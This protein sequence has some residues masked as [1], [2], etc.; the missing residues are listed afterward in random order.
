[1]IL[2]LLNVCLLVILLLKR[3]IGVGVLLSIASLLVWM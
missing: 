1:L 2:M 3:V